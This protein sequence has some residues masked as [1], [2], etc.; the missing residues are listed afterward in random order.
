MSEKHPVRVAVIG[1]GSMARGH[2]RRM[3]RQQDST[4]ITVLCDPSE[5][6]YR[7]GTAGVHRCRTI[8]P[9]ERAKP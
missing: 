3:L 8:P 6:I 2:V 7:A 5:R 4:E 1:C 9:P